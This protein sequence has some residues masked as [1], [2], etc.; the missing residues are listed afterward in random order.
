MLARLAVVIDRR[1]WLLLAVALVITAI[2]APLG[3]HVRDHLKPRRTHAP[4]RAGGRRRSRRHEHA[5]PGHGRR[6]G[7]STYVIAAVRRLSDS[8]QEDP[9]RRL[10]AASAGDRRVTLGGNPVAN[11]EISK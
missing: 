3:L 2:A 1:P 9:G 5:Q 4:S 6:D 7:R 11:H 8:Q 10:L